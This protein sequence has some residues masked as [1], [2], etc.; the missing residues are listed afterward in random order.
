MAYLEVKF[1]EN[2]FEINS[3]AFCCEIH[4]TWENRKVWFVILRV[5]CSSETG[6]PLFS[7]QAIADAFMYKA[8]QNINNF[9]REYE[10]CNENLFD[11]LRHKRK[12]DPGVVEAV[13]EELRKNVLIKSGELRIRV[14]Q[15]LGRDDL[16]SANIRVALGQIPCT[17]IRGTVLR[18]IAQGS[19]HPKEEVVL[20]ELFAAFIFEQGAES[21]SRVHVS[22]FSPRALP[23]PVH[24]RKEDVV[25][26]NSGDGYERGEDEAEGEAEGEENS[27][28][29]SERS[30]VSHDESGHSEKLLRYAEIVSAAGIEAIREEPD[31]AVIQKIQADSVGKLLSPNVGLSEIPESVVEMVKAMTMYHSGASLSRIGCWFGGKANSTIYTWIMG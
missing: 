30:V 5:L 9:V 11:Y 18:E 1:N 21:E 31:E 15:R 14:N 26:V 2:R 29:E 23:L 12:V 28:A 25:V 3:Q 20:A 10:Q 13:S 6:K 8:R 16:T 27:D 22:S 17:V 4:D 19:F 7:Y 24:A